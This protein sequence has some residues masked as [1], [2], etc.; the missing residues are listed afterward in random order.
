MESSALASKI[1]KAQ[2]STLQKIL[3]EDAGKGRLAKPLTISRRIGTED[4]DT[5]AGLIDERVTMSV[6]EQ[7][8]HSPYLTAATAAILAG[9][10]STTIRKWADLKYFST[11]CLGG[12]TKNLKISK[13]SFRKWLIGQGLL[14]PGFT[15]EKC[16]VK[17]KRIETNRPI[18]ELNSTAADNA[19]R[20][21]AKACIDKKMT[22]N[23]KLDSIVGMLNNLLF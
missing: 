20:Y 6:A 19:I 8:E 16:P 14:V 22:S 18:L 13:E 4:I 2:V 11:V 1:S 17:E 3:E 23:E 7:I 10:S 21:I 9:V 15:A 12:D 5:V